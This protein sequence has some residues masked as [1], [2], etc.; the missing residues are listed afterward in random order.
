MTHKRPQTRKYM[1]NPTLKLGD[2]MPAMVAVIP[3]DES[4]AGAKEA[5]IFMVGVLIMAYDNQ[6]PPVQN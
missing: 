5:A 1:P 2:C 6:K 3:F 4:E